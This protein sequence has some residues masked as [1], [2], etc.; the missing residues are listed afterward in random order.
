VRLVATLVGVGL[1]MAT[2]A[3]VHAETWTC[4]YKGKWVTTKTK[5]SDTMDWLLKWESA[6][7]GTW[8]VLG[9]YND[10]YGHAWFDGTCSSGSCDF[11]QD[12]KQGKLAG[13]K[14]Y[15][16][17]TYSDAQID[18]NTTT[19]TFA[20]TWG[21]KPDNRTN[22]GTWTSVATCKKELGAK[23][24]PTA[25]TPSKP[26]PTPPPSPKQGVTGNPT[27]ETL[28]D[29]GG[30]SAWSVETGDTTYVVGG[31]VPGGTEMT[32]AATLYAKTGKVVK[33]L[34]ATIPDADPPNLTELNKLKVAVDKALDH[35]QGNRLT[36]HALTASPVTYENITMKWDA[37]T[38]TL[39]VFDG[40]KLFKKIVGKA[41]GKGMKLDEAKVSLFEA[42]SPPAAV[43]QLGYSELEGIST[44]RQVIVFPL[45]AV[46]GG[47]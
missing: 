9:D 14:Y 47:D 46:E 23:T 4:L 31:C 42:G 32:C 44:D 40:K 22:G 20:G 36:D 45:P 34:D 7:G 6:A 17:G 3:P 26:A 41:A 10:K 24:A 5:N 35:N 27:V 15:F 11:T 16:T 2:A 25:P 19:N 12:Y 33:Q 30:Y 37:K 28:F 8:K 18:D 1:A 29:Q 38:R 43:L 21:Y 13:K 39:S